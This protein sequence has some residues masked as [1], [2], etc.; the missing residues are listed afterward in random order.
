MK[1]KVYKATTT[2]SG[3]EARVY[4]EVDVEKIIKQELVNRLVELI[5]DDVFSIIYRTDDLL[6]DRIIFSTELI[7]I[8]RKDFDAL[9][10]AA[11]SNIKIYDKRIDD[12]VLL[13]DLI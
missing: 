4:T 9:R 7:T 5:K 8:S 1:H 11:E 3:Q 10:A 12:Y 6:S 13:S 2:I